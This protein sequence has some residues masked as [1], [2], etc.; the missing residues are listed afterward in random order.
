[1]D[2]RHFLLALAAGSACAAWA[3]APPLPAKFD[4]ARD[5]EADLAAALA[6]AR[7][8]RKHVIVDVGGE[9][10]PWCHILDRFIARDDDVRRIVESRYVWLKVNYSKENKNEKFLARWPKVAGYPHL[11]VL[12]AAGRLI[13]SQNTGELEAGKDYDKEKMLAFLKRYAP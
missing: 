7:D 11:Y 12:D 8:G 10:C 1:M 6:I 13:Y 9:W 5:A 2:K 4:P 3:A